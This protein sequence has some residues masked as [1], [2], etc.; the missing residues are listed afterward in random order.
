MSITLEQF[1]GMMNELA[2][3]AYAYDWDNSGTTLATHEKIT[4]VLVCVDVTRAV[5]EEAVRKDCDTVLSHHPL[6]FSAVKTLH[7]MH[8]VTGLA[9]YAAAH[10]LNLYAAHTSCDCAPGGVNTALANALRLINTQVLLPQPGM[11]GGLGMVG[12]LPREMDAAAL[13]EHVKQA[14]SARGVRFGAYAGKISRLAVIGGAAGEFFLEARAAGAQALLVGEAKYNHYLDA[15]QAGVLLLEAGHYET[16]A[17]F[18]RTMCEGL[19]MRANALQYKLNVEASE[20]T[21]PPYNVL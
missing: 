10:G 13:A 15:A 2:P 21:S 7:Y 9:L 16:E 11:E 14:L 20:V 18:V 17:G 3:L 12:E 6:L 8:P 19:Q 1:E 4:R 5:L